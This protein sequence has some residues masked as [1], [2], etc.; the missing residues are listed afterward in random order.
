MDE[1]FNTYRNGLT[2]CPSCLSETIEE[3]NVTRHGLRYT[4]EAQRQQ[5]RSVWRVK[6]DERD[7]LRYRITLLDTGKNPRGIDELTVDVTADQE[8]LW[9]LLCN[10][11]RFSERKCLLNELPLFSGS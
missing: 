6:E 3:V 2:S 7:A 1:V 4:T 11:S 5:C 10:C 8:S 9:E